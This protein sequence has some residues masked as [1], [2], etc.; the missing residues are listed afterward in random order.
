MERKTRQRA[1][2]LKVFEV[3]SGPMSPQEVLAKAKEQ[4]PDLGIATV[5]RNI[6]SFVE[7]GDLQTVPLPGQPDRYE[8]AGKT[9]HHH[10]YCRSCQRAFEMTGCPGS[11]DHLAPAG[12]VTEGHEIY[13]Y[14]RCHDCASTGG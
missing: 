11:L 12:F 7:R 1:S 8:I 9:H 6:K 3:S 10:F 14:G 5:Y 4:L 2:I 13:L